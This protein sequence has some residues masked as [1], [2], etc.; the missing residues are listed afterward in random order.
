MYIPFY[1]DN[2]ISLVAIIVYIT[3]ISFS[4]YIPLRKY[5]GNSVLK[6]VIPISLS[7]YILISYIFYS[8]R[9][10]NWFIVFYFPFLIL[11]N[12]YYYWKERPFFQKIYLLKK[13][14]LLLLLL[15]ISAVFS[16]FYF[17]IFYLNKNNPDGLVH[18]DMLE[19]IN[20]LGHIKNVF[21]APGFHL[22]FFPI[23]K[24]VNNYDIMRFGGVVIGLLFLFCIYILFAG[25]LKHRIAR[26]LLIAVFVSPFA[27][28]L[29]LQTIGFF[30]SS[31]GFIFF[32]YILY[33]LI[34][35]INRIKISEMFVMILVNISLAL[36][37]PYLTFQILFSLFLI[38]VIFT[39]KRIAT[40]KVAMFILV[41]FF[42]I[43]I[44][45]G[46]VFSQTKII[47][48]SGGFPQIPTYQEGNDFI[49]NEA[50]ILKNNTAE[51]NLVEIIAERY[52]D[53]SLFQSMVLPVLNTSFDIFKF[54]Q[55]LNLKSIYGFGLFIVLL[56]CVYLI[57][58]C[59]R[60]K[61]HVLLVLSST[62]FYYGFSTY[63]GLF[64]MST[65]RGRNGWY[66]MLVFF[67][68][69]VVLVDRILLKLKYQ[70]KE[71]IILFVIIF[72]SLSAII[73]P[74]KSPLYIDSN[75]LKV[76]YKK[77]RGCRTKIN[78]ISD[79]N[80]QIKMMCPNINSFSIYD[81]N[82][83]NLIGKDKTIILMNN[84]RIDRTSIYNGIIFSVEKE[85]ELA[86][87]NNNENILLKKQIVEIKGSKLF[88]KYRLKEKYPSFD[89]YS[90]F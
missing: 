82:M 58:K 49:G 5:T 30:S 83:K 24:V 54:K 3:I 60:T 85:I 2:F 28:K 89:Y 15:T 27:A 17:S 74:V 7:F 11:L 43:M 25:F 62:L 12:L 90:N 57:V 47:N 33:L 80:F 48:N 37:L 20:S 18:L 4:L 14:Y 81:K 40:K 86:K 21:Y 31:L 76:V 9:I 64:E 42:G 70:K 59:L 32:V 65:Y 84:P 10:I 75:I 66:F 34:C 68:V 87:K 26:I 56:F 51:R 55:L 73:F 39:S 53:N 45:Y 50:D 38:F 71:G 67:I 35:N 8:F 69:L 22:I 44:G 23:S 63:T 79:Y 13:Q 72:L 88:S 1:W 6:H 16:R 29:N 77:T 78:V 61:D 46:H 36:T 41:T 52:S 19:N